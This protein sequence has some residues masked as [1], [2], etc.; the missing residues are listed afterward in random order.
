MANSVYSINK[1]INKPIEFQGLKAQYIAYLAVGLVALL[2]L[3]LVMYLVGLNLYICVVLVFGLGTVLIMA[4]FQLN[5][6][7]GRYGLMKKRAK[8]GM[9][10]YLRFHSRKLF[11]RLKTDQ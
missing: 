2:L 7:Y 9:P 1:G 4:V 8:G 10:V 3:F 5:R 6:K 11:T